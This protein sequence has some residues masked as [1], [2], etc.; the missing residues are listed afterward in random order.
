MSSHLCTVEIHKKANFFILMMSII[1]FIWNYTDF[2]GTT[3]TL[4]SPL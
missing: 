3:L 1:L 2:L 4:T